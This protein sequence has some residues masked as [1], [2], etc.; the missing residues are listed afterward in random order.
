MSDGNAKR[1]RLGPIEKVAITASILSFLGL[2]VFHPRVLFDLVKLGEIPSLDETA[3]LVTVMFG[4]G[5]I[6]FLLAHL[7]DDWRIGRVLRRQCR[8]SLRAAQ[9]ALLAIL[10]SED[11]VNS[12]FIAT[13][14]A[15]GVFVGALPNWP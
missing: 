2:T 9:L 7:L 4:F 1:E 11:V 6:P 14:V 15:F 3:L 8:R 5:R 10:P 12:L 13:L